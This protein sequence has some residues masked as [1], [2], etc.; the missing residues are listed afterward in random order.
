ME[1]LEEKLGN[2][3]DKNS[4]SFTTIG[5]S[6][7][8]NT[9]DGINH[10]TGIMRFDEISIGN[11]LSNSSI[12]KYVW[13]TYEKSFSVSTPQVIITVRN[14]QINFLGG[15]KSIHPR[16][17]SERII[18]RRSGLEIIRKLKNINFSQ[19]L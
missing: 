1:T 15:I 17:E 19:I 18:I 3:S 16:I 9:I 7:E 4:Y 8:I 13:E 6:N 2:F 10:L 11:S 12:Q 14:F 5:I